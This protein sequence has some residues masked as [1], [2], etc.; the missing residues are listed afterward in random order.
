MKKAYLTLSLCII[1]FIISAQSLEK[2]FTP[3]YLQNDKIV[4]F[5]RVG[6]K[7]ESKAIGFG[8]GGVNSYYT[9]FNSKNSSTQFKSNELPKFLIKTE[10]NT[11]VLELVV[12]TKADVVKKSKTYR[13]FVISGQNIMFAGAKDFSDLKILP[14][15]KEIDTNLYEMVF[16]KDLEP[17]EYTFM[18]IFKG[19]Q[20]SNL[21]TSTGKTILYCFGISNE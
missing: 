16:N 2:S 10:D 5:E 19:Q 3:Y 14:T 4:E 12:L 21:T 11:E 18:P 9:I 13:R 8:Y 20:S 6:A 1:S 7:M 17:G 15:L